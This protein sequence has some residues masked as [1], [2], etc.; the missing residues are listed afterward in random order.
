MAAIVGAPAG[1]VQGTRRGR[2]EELNGEGGSVSQYAIPT[3][4]ECHGGP[5]GPGGADPRRTGCR[6][7]VIV[8][9]APLP[10]RPTADAADRADDGVSRAARR[11]HADRPQHPDPA[12]AQSGARGRRV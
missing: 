10:D 12:V 1:L 11:G 2:A 8:V 3:W 7:Q 9:P 6:L 5:A 4:T